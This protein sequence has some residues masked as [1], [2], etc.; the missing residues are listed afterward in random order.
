MARQNLLCACQRTHTHVQHVQHLWYKKHIN[1]PN[2]PSNKAN[3]FGG[4]QFQGHLYQP[5]SC[6]WKALHLQTGSRLRKRTNQTGIDVK[7]AREA[8]YCSKRMQVVAPRVLVVKGRAKGEHQA[9]SPKCNTHSMHTYESLAH[10]LFKLVDRRQA[11]G[12]Y[13][14]MQVQL[15]QHTVRPTPPGKQASRPAY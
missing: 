12:Q 10:R 15:I 9:S 6:S 4:S 5:A 11:D 2:H 7:Q 1:N 3:G 13:Q 14:F 8:E